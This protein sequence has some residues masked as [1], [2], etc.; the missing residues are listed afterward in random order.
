MNFSDILIVVSTFIRS[1]FEVFLPQQVIQYID[2][3][4]N[5]VAEKGNGCSLFLKPN[6]LT[7]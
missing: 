5:R 1:P 3:F 4:N 7:E 6:F 2:T